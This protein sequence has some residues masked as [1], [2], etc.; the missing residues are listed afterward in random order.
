MHAF[1]KKFL[2]LYSSSI[3]SKVV[4]NRSLLNHFLFF[5]FSFWSL[6]FWPILEIYSIYLFMVDIFVQYKK[7]N[8]QGIQKLQ[9]HTKILLFLKQQHCLDFL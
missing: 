2:S 3:E 9:I 5:S 7:T 4:K 8:T 1:F 6:M